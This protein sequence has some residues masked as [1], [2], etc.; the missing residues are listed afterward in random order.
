MPATARTGGSFRADSPPGGR[1][2]SLCLAILGALLATGAAASP[3]VYPTGVTLYDPDLA[4]GSYIVFGGADGK[5]HLIDMDGNEVHRWAHFG[6][7]SKLLEP[8]LTG[9]Q[10]GDVLVQLSQV[11]DDEAARTGTSLAPGEKLLHGNRTVGELDW[12]GRV[13]W[14]WGTQ[15]P[16]G[17]ARQHHD[18]DRLPSGDTLILANWIHGVPGFKARPLFDDV[19]YEV[20]PKGAIVWRWVAS[21]HL[22]QFG[23]SASSLR[24]LRRSGLQD[25]L[26]I[27]DMTPLGPNRWFDAGD[28]RF[29]PGNIL[30]DSRQ[31]NFVVIIDRKTG[32]VVWRIGP[33]ERSALTDGT[34]VPRPI[35]QTSGQHDA[36]LIPPGLPGAGDLLVF[37][38]QGEAGYPPRPLAVMPGSRVLQINPV[39]KQIVWQYTATDSGQPPWGFYSSFISSAQ[40]LPNGNT[41]IDEGMDGRIFQVTQSGR[42]VW[43]YVSP[44][45]AP[46]PLFGGKSVVSNYVYRAQAVPYDWVPAGTPH[47]Q[48]PVVAPADAGF[49]VP[50]EA[51]APQWR[52]ER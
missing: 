8:R 44:Y 34:A 22:R 29:D 21:Q 24:L 6:F 38:N 35:D 32:H 45:F 50:G 7:P 25:Y 18:I 1:V 40:R 42:I 15:A 46:A 19:I 31:A 10:R 27:N 41:L 12:S 26:H 51:A 43:E 13:L 52:Q 23:F 20:T 36:H 33:N 48:R 39:T 16:G 14:Q 11:T 37:D 49:R 28:K 5:T 9:G 30:I 17:A 47:E 3:S 2:R 4:Y